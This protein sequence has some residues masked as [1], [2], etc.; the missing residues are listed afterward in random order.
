MRRCV[1]PRTLS[2]SKELLLLLHEWIVLRMIPS[3]LA[4]WILQLCFSS[5]LSEVNDG[6]RLAESHLLWLCRPWRGGWWAEWAS[7]WI[8]CRGNLVTLLGWLE[9]LPTAP[10]QASLYPPAEIMLDRG[11][12]VDKYH[13][14]WKEVTE[15]EGMCRSACGGRS[16]TQ[17][18]SK[19]QTNLDLDQK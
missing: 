12:I 6:G 10:P 8:G 2:A 19:K 17:M 4:W 18:M 1:D 14:M 9:P 11:V 13:M 5:G 16:N 7:N 15:E 3:R